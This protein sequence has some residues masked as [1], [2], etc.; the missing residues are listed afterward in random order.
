MV[1]RI[2][3]IRYLVSSHRTLTWDHQS[4]YNFFPNDLADISLIISVYFISFIMGNKTG[5]LHGKPGFVLSTVLP[6][7]ML[8]RYSCVLRKI[9]QWRPDFCFYA[10]LARNTS[11]WYQ[12]YNY[13]YV[14]VLSSS[15]AIVCFKSILNALKVSFLLNFKSCY[16]CIFTKGII[17][18]NYK[19]RNTPTAIGTET[20]NKLHVNLSLSLLKQQF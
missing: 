20:K 11:Y 8:T 1:E 17:F 16:S 4:L 3:R 10:I 2:I 12:E 14:C 13:Y 15:D 6:V 18:F 7:I 19:G 5:D 9:L